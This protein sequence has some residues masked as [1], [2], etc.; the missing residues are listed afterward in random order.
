VDGFFIWDHVAMS[1]PQPLV[2]PW[3]ALAAIATTTSRIRI[4]TMVTPLARRHPWQLA[5]ETVSLDHLSGGRLVLGAGLGDSNQEFEQ[6]GQPRDAKVRVA[7][8]D[9]GLEVLTGLWSAEPFSYRG[10]HYH[11]EAAGFT[12]APLQSPRIP[13]WVAGFWPKKAPFRRAARYD[14]VFPGKIGGDLTPTDVR[15]ILSYVRSNRTRESNFEAVIMNE[16]P[17]DKPDEA[18]NIVAPFAE[19]GATWWL[20]PIHN[21]R[22]TF[23]EM[24]TR[25][26]QGPPA[27]QGS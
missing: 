2:D 22:G 3:V 27:I 16:T 4:G 13:I 12:P 17:G 14:G 1:P 21:W 26:L 10:E 6:F 25:V 11:V 5:R 20:E 9:E 18:A 23:D 19:A 8:L 7:M 15:E 24:R